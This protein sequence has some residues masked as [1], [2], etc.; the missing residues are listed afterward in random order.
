MNTKYTITGKDK[1]GKRFVIN[2]N[3]PQQYNIW[4]GTIWE[5]VANNK[6]KLVWRYYN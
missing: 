1:Q 3:T 5:N 2:T 6:R 4:A